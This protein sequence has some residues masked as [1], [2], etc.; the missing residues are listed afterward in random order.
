M[1]NA[2]KPLKVLYFVNGSAPS[3]AQR[4][5]AETYGYGTVFR[6][7]Q[8]VP[9]TG[10]LETCDAVAGDVPA[11]YQKQF[12]IAARIMTR[13]N[14]AGAP[15]PSSEA[16]ADGASPPAG[17]DTAAATTVGLAQSQP[18]LAAVVIPPVAPASASAAPGPFPGVAAAPAAPPVW[19]SNL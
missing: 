10:A 11:R 6:N 1:A 18:D 14:T 12:P 15:V 9:I 16:P 19:K 17:A 5:D 7:A 3:S 13:T 8:H 4:L 2:A